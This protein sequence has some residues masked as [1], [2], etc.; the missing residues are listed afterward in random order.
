MRRFLRNEGDT[1]E[2]GAALAGTLRPGM[3]IHLVGDLGAGKTTFARGVLRGLGFIGRVKSP[4][5]TVVEVY[6]LSRLDFYHFDFY[7]FEDPQELR[8]AGLGEYFRSDAVCLVEWP[9]KVHGLPAP[10]VRIVLEVEGD[11]RSITLAAETEAGRFCLTRMFDS[12][13]H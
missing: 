10:D 11:G 3:S 8:E 6:E 12:R 4:T 9:E 2:L 7:R 5:F 13:P 1:L